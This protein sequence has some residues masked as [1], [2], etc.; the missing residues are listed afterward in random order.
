MKSGE[1][2][3]DFS[4]RIRAHARVV[5]LIVH[6]IN[7]YCLTELPKVRAAPGPIGSFPGSV[8]GRKKNCDEES[9]DS[10]DDEKLDQCKAKLFVLSSAH[11]TRPFPP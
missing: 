1:E 10:D 4:V 9:D 6:C 3:G 2:T 11:R 8:K 5:P 7:I